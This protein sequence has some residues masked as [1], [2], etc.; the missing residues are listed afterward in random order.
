MLKFNQKCLLL[1][2]ITLTL[3]KKREN[4]DQ[5]SNFK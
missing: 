3:K 2:Q 4:V 1:Y 5:R